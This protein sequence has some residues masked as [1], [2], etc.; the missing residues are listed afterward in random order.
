MPDP[1]SRAL[2]AAILAFIKKHR[3]SPASE[4]AFNELAGRLFTHQFQRNRWLRRLSELEGKTPGNVRHWKQIPAV[5]AMA[6]KQLRLASFPAKDQ[7][8]VFYTSG[9]TRKTRGIHVFDT[10]RLYEAALVGPFENTFLKKGE[11][12]SYYFLMESPRSAPHS[13][14]SHM[15]G[16]VNARFAG[17]HGRFYVRQGKADLERLFQDLSKEKGKVFLLATA[18]SLTAFLDKLKTQKKGLRLKVG[19]RL[20]ETGG[21][22]GR[23]TEISKKELYAC[24]QKMLG[25]PK[26][27]CFGEYGMTEL[28]S[29][30]YAKAG[31]VFKGPAWMRT[32]VIDPASGEEVPKGRP[33]LLRHFDLANRG[34]VMAIQTEDVGMAV[35]DGFRLTGR[36][37]GSEL[38]GCSLSYESLIGS[39]A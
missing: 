15:M 35:G 2:D 6:F 22:K 26:K 27:A 10:L 32:L 1:K 8:K 4:S 17:G 33:G 24:C 20:M 21:F 34:S 38:R 23:I 30:M 16:V 11:K 7:K 13:S 14:L 19:S 25:L 5:P 37:S 36:A 31:G 28:S 29:Q 3:Q 12:L 9:T 18:F 39:A